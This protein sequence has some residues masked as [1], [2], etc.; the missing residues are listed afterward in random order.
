MEM[1]KSV[2]LNVSGP[3]GLLPDIK[4]IGR[5]F[6]WDRVIMRNDIIHV[7]GL[8]LYANRH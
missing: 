5:A 7:S 4:L 2:R 8:F 3:Q 6:S 1:S